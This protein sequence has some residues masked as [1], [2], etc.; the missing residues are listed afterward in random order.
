MNDEAPAALGGKAAGQRAD[1][2]RI[3]ATKSPGCWLADT[4]P[5]S[6]D[7]VAL[8]RK[9]LERVRDMLRTHDYAACVLFDPFNQRYATGSRN[10]FGYFLRNSTRY[11]FVP[12][13]GPVILFEYPGSAHVSMSLETIQEARTS[14]LVWSS[15]LRRDADTAVAFAAEIA[16]LVRTYGG[17]NRRVGLDR[18]THGLAL[19]LDAEGCQ[20]IDCQQDM[21]HARRIKTDEEIACLKLSM[22]AAEEGVAALREA[23]RPGI[24]EQ[25]LFGLLY[26]HV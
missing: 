2:G 19:A 14:K 18:C 3:R 26:G 25:E 12:A 16:D 24:A 22:A 1:G 10:M 8:R 6:F 5:P 20:T 9:R 17:G 7:P 21:L 23:I 15:V 4:E 13:D 11:F